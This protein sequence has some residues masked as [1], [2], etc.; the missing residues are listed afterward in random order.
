[1][2][3]RNRLK[4]LNQDNILKEDYKKEHFNNE[5]YKIQV[6]HNEESEIKVLLNDE[7]KIEY[8]S[9]EKSKIDDIY[10]E[11]YKIEDLLNEN[12]Y[13]S[14]TPDSTKLSSNSS[15]EGLSEDY[16]GQSDE[17]RIINSFIDPTSIELSSEQTSV[18]P[19]KNISSL[20]SLPLDQNATC[21]QYEKC[22]SMP[23]DDWIN[24]EYLDIKYKKLVSKYFKNN[25]DLINSKF[26]IIDNTLKINIKNWGTEYFYIENINKNTK[27]YE[28][29]YE[30][31]YNIYDLAICIQIGNWD[32][33]TKM[34]PYIHNLDKININYY[35]TIIDEYSTD[36]NINYLISNYKN[37]V[38]LKN[39]NKGMD[40]GLFFSSLHYIK[41]KNI[42]HNFLIKIHTKTDD[43]IRNKILN[44]LLSSHNKIINNIK[45][46]TNSKNG[47]VGGNTIYEYNSDRHI[48]INNIY[49]LN[50][51]SNYLYNEPIDN[52]KLKF[53]ETTMFIIKQECLRIFTI[54]NIEYIYN[55]L[56]DFHSIDYSWYAYYYNLDKNNKKEILSHYFDNPNDRYLSNLNFQFKTNQSDLRDYMIEHA[57]ERFFGYMCLKEGLEIIST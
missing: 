20:T 56:N 32:I 22:L 27:F 39:K 11:E 53:V 23:L 18:E 38:I 24:I 35:F 44:N 4:R 19:I 50:D 49:H 52:N 8:I 42:N 12:I 15:N 43:D 26:K 30:N 34:E 28:I 31:I 36:K 10:N 1:M 25:L 21:E 13:F 3:R 57:C 9:N 48:F 5:E 16:S 6:I 41:I 14:I 7:S 17:Y 33:F 40:I 51:L 54:S 37:S 46:L 55:L 45:L 29:I 47:I 2:N